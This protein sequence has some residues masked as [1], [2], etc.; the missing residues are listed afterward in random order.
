M[1]TSKIIFGIVLSLI[2]ILVAIYAYY[3]GFSKID[4][5][6][7][8]GGGE[9]LVYQSLK[10][11]YSQTAM[12]TDEIYEILLS[13]Y[14]IETFKGFGIY[15]DNPAEVTTEELR[16]DVGCI[17]PEEHADKKPMLESEF[18]VETAPYGDFVVTEFPYRGQL[19]FMV[20]VM[21]VYPAMTRFIQQKGLNPNTPVMEIYDIPNKK[22]IY[23]KE[24]VEL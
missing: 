21:K 18:K 8:Q 16:S 3:G 9:T 17:L 14:D 23:R 20:G 1:K 12:V 19:S 13:D 10:G 2:L 15:Y 4:F 22:I 6:V 11:D 24:M 5:E 7:R